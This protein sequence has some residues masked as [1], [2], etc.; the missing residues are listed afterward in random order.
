MK[1]QKLKY[2]PGTKMKKANRLSRRIDQKIGIDKNN[3]NQ[4]IN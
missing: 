2:V 3:E 1:M 4:K